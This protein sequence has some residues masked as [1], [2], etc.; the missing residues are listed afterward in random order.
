R[1]T[2][3]HPDPDRRGHGDRARVLLGLAGRGA[4][5][6]HD[7]VHRR[8]GCRPSQAAAG[9]G[10]GRAAGGDRRRRAVDRLL[11]PVPDRRAGRDAGQLLRA[12]DATGQGARRGG[13]R[14]LHLRPRTRRGAR[15]RERLPRRAVLEPAAGQHGLV[16]VARRRQPCDEPKPPAS[17]SV[18]RRRAARRRRPRGPGRAE[19][20][21]HRRPPY[22]PVDVPLV[23]VGRR[24]APDHRG[25]AGRRH[26]V[27]RR[28]RAGACR[29]DRAPPA[30][31]RLA[32]PHVTVLSDTLAEAARRFP[33]RDAVVHR[34]ITLT[35]RELDGLATQVAA[36]LAKAGVGRADVVALMLPA[37]PEYVVAYLALARLGAIPTGVSPRAAADERSKMIGRAYPPLLIATE[38]L[39]DGVPAGVAVAD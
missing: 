24:S 15:R 9:C 2:G 28:R 5:D 37:G 30:A 13:V 33:D 20:A 8:A 10:R 27:G 19:L 11:E 39:A 7:R 23:L 36:G 18:G 3:R 25:R 38:E 16:R 26:S 31:H 21:R 1:W 35:Y 12:G 17:P 34:D 22:R 29:G 4:G 32:V 14:V 6:V